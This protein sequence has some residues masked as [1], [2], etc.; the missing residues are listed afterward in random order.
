MYIKG[1]NRRE[2]EELILKASNKANMNIFI[3]SNNEY[4]FQETLCSNLDAIIQG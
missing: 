2:Y 4:L 3:P 1:E